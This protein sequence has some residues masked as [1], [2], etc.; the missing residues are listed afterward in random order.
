[1]D[2]VNM[3]SPCAYVELPIRNSTFCPSSFSFRLSG[4]S[5]LRVSAMDILT[6]VYVKLLL[7][8]RESRGLPFFNY[9]QAVHPEQLSVPV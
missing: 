2:P 1:M 8:L 9:T 7:S 6:Y 5:R 4:G 3:G